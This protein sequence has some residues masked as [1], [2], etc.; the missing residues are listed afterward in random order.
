MCVR[1]HISI[2]NIYIHRYVCIY[3]HAD[4]H[5]HRCSPA[6]DLADPS[7]SFEVGLAGDESVVS[8]GAW[9]LTVMCAQ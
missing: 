9:L 6:A 7:T 4:T 1:T 8:S 5:V 2:K 3:T